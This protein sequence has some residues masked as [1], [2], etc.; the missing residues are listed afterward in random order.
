MRFIAMD[1]EHQSI[2][3]LWALSITTDAYRDITTEDQV[4]HDTE[5]QGQ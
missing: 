1:N 2:H 4:A 5:G 3:V